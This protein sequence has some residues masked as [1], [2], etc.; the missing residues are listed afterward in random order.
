MSELFREALR[1][2]ER[3]SLTAPTSFAEAVRLLRE[4][5]RAKGTDRL[6]PREINAEIAAVRRIRRKLTN[7]AA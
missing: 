3:E 2:Y 4:D 6:S 1:R 5:A 7:P